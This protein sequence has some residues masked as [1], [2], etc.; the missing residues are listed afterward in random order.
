MLAT[1]TTKEADQQPHAVIDAEIVLAARAD[2]AS[3]EPDRRASYRPPEMP[4]PKIDP[5]LRSQA[6]NGLAAAGERSKVGTWIVRTMLAVLFAVGSAVAAAAWQSYGDEAQEMIAHWMPRISLVSSADKDGTAPPAATSGQETAAATQAQAQDP[7]TGTA[8]AGASLEQ[9]QLL[10]S[11]AHDLAALS[12][13]ISD[14][15]TGLAQLKTGQEQLARDVARVAEARPTERTA[16]ARSFDPRAIEQTLRPRPA[17]R[18]TTAAITPPP[19]A[20]APAHRPRPV[21][22]AANMVPP[23]PAPMSLQS[24]P[25]DPDQPVVRPPMPV[26]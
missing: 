9:A 21:S 17:P 16:E 23:P 1:T 2:R 11:M 14:L 13:Q 7:A 24:A 3:A 10:Q 6:T 12:Q 4:S 18:P 20:A 19:A 5:E 22:P 26:R 8:A 25:A 15:K